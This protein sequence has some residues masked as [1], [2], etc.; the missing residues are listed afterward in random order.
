M[1]VV[2]CTLRTS[3]LA[4][5]SE[6]LHHVQQKVLRRYVMRSAD[7]RDLQNAQSYAHRGHEEELARID[8]A[9]SREDLQPASKQ[10]GGYEAKRET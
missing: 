10:P 3:K 4:T 5:G 6:F 9:A 2:F 1:S 7:H 8:V